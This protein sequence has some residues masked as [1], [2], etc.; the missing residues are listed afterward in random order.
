MI[1]PY[2]TTS[3]YSR[4]RRL[5]ATLIVGVLAAMGLATASAASTASAAISAGNYVWLTTD[6]GTNVYERGARALGPLPPPGGGTGPTIANQAQG[7]AVF[8][9]ALNTVLI[10]EADGIHLY[11]P[12][13]LNSERVLTGS[14]YSGG[15]TDLTLSADATELA[16]V[17]TGGQAI[18]FLRISDSSLLTTSNFLTPVT[19]LSTTP[20]PVSSEFAV[21]LSYE[22][23]LGYRTESFSAGIGPGAGFLQSTTVQTMD[24]AWSLDG[25]YL[26]AAS[27]STN[28]AENGIT[29]FDTQSRQSEFFPTPQGFAPQRLLMSSAGDRL[30]V[31]ASGDGGRQGGVYVIDTASMTFENFGLAL[32]DTAAVAYGAMD[33]AIGPDGDS[34]LYVPTGANLVAVEFGE[35]GPQP[36]F[37]D[38]QNATTYGAAVVD[39]PAEWLITGNDQSTFIS[40]PFAQ[41][42]VVV[43]RDIDGTPMRGIPLWAEIMFG[44]V[45]YS[46]G[47]TSFAG[48]TD[49]NGQFTLPA[50]DVGT[51]TGAVEIQVT[52]P[53]SEIVGVFTLEILSPTAPGP[54]VIDSLTAGDST[55]SVAFTP[56]TAGSLPTTQ[57]VAT[58]TNQSDADQLDIS[59]AG[60]ASPILVSGLTNGETYTFTVTAINPAGD[61]ESAASNA[62]TVGI[63]A[64]VTALPGPATAGHAYSFTFAPA[65]VPT[66]TMQLNVGTPLPDGLTWDADTMT[67]HGTPAASSVGTTFLL[68]FVSNELANDVQVPVSF[69]VDSAVGSVEPGATPVLQPAGPEPIAHAHTTDVLAVTGG[70]LPVIAIVVGIGLLFAGGLLRAIRPVS[71]RAAE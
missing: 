27:N 24:T 52:G 25:T 1:L 57:Y 7:P 42:L 54:P 13:A 46:G 19:G 41:P 35:M 12:I 62:I 68:F 20:P 5:A 30:Y 63:P 26:Y 55:V 22:S 67:I 31:A 45:T 71:R 6:S 17:R 61:V 36:S 15:Y 69:V 56:G 21:T 58:A 38:I 9:R 33:V 23:Q 16:A 28:P 66:P 48:V 70:Q 53:D 10:P 37:V 44:D 43:P 65:G 14:G 2:P 49:A 4:A 60:T 8:S 59:G 47:G 3:P 34:S 11:D 51:T 40:T 18:D 64:S 29:R 50:L 32:P 39:L